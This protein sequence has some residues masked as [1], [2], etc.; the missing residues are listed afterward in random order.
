MP[1][2]FVGVCVNL[3]WKNKNPQKELSALLDGAL[4]RTGND[5]NVA[6]LGEMWQGGGKGFS[7]IVMVTLGTGVG[8]GARNRR[9][10]R[11]SAHPRRGEGAVQLRR[12]WLSGAGGLRHGNRQ[13][14]QKS[15]GAGQL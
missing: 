14:S 13:G 6:A 4:V 2:G 12:L 9:R 7:D 3:G 10:D 1:D 11:T 5:A 15:H 8:G